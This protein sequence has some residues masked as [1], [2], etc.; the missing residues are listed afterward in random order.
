MLSEPEAD[1]AYDFS[2]GIRGSQQQ[3]Y[4]LNLAGEFYVTA[5]LILERSRGHAVGGAAGENCQLAGP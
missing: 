1:H 4:P 3:K 2:T 5:E